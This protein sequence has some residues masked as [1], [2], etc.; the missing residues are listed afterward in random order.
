MASPCRIAAQP[1]TLT[2]GGYRVSVPLPG[3][4]GQHLPDRGR[5]AAKV[6]RRQACDSICSNRGY[7]SLRM[8]TST[9]FRSLSSRTNWLVSV[10]P[11]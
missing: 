5:G 8:R 1:L 6:F 11:K 3:T 2:G 10:F 7:G 4:T 9:F